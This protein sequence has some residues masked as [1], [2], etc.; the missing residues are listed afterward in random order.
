[1]ALKE[2]VSLTMK[3]KIIHI[4]ISKSVIMNME[5]CGGV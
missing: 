2:Q 5:G 3:N 1:M 4:S